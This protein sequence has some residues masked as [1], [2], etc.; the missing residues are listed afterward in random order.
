MRMLLVRTVAAVC[1]SALSLHALPAAAQSAPSSWT[2]ELTLTVKR[3]P[4]VVPVARRHAGRLRRRRGRDGGRAQRVGQPDPPRRPPTARAA[5]KSPAATSRR[6]IRAGR[7]TAGSM[8]FVSSRSGKANIW[9]INVSG[10]EAEQ[11]TDEKGGVSA[12]DWSPDGTSFAFVMR[13]AK[14]EAEEKADKEKRDWRTLDEQVKMNRLYVVPVDKGV[15]RQADGAAADEGGALGQRVLLGARRQD[16]RVRSP[17]DAGRRRL[18]VGRPRGRD[19]GRRRRDVRSRRARATEDQ[20]DLLAGRALHRLHRQR[21]SAVVGVRA[22]RSTSC[23]RPA[24]R[25]AR[26]PPRSTRSRSSSAG[27][28]TAARSW[29]ARRTA[30]AAACSR[31]PSTAR[32]AVVLGARRLGDRGVAEPHRHGARLRR[33]GRRSRAGAVRARR[34]ARRSRRRRSPRCSRR[35]RPRSAAP[36]R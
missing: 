35:S 36:S 22:A 13:D 19:G 16:D 4:T 25:R 11:I 3:V 26:W 33:P 12:F 28:A 2:P 15:R 6:A 7:P 30:C 5:V 20:A 29:S 21:R 34:S 27:R 31:S 14:S 32:P 23:P 17:E 1:A 8:A 9:R 10:G 18:A 24:A